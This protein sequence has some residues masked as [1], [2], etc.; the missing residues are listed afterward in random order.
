MSGDDILL[1]CWHL[2]KEEVVAL[3]SI[4]CKEGECLVNK[5]EDEYNQG[6]SISV[7]LQIHSRN[8]DKDIISLT[9]NF[10]L[11]KTYPKSDPPVIS[12]SCDQ[13]T[14]QHILRVLHDVQLYSRT[15]LPESCLF[16]V[17]ER[18]KGGVLDIE[19]HGGTL[20]T[21]LP[22]ANN[23]SGQVILIKGQAILKYTLRAC[24]MYT[25]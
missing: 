8:T 7:A 17:L 6:I 16:D 12:I 21:L 2:R 15:C 18:I 24:D 9:T 4:Y 10:Q 14:R 19:S 3:Q 13:L 22:D 1:E 25:L 11:P 5:E 23:G 20:S